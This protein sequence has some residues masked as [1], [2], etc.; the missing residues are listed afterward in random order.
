MD[1]Y[2]VKY[3]SYGLGALFAQLASTPENRI[4]ITDPIC[5][6]IKL[7]ILAC[8][9]NNT[10]ISLKSNKIIIQEAGMLQGVQRWWNDDDRDKLHQLKYPLLYFSGLRLG[11][12][13]IDGCDIKSD[14]YK[15]LCVMAIKGLNKLKMTYELA[16]KKHGSMVRNCLDDYI[17]SLSKDYTKEEFEKEFEI[18]NK[19]TLFIIYNEFMKKW[20]NEYIIMVRKLFEI[21]FQNESDNI[22]NEIANAINSLIDAKD[23]EIDS[24]R[25]D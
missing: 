23:L 4:E 6:V 17:K 5:S 19:P 20:N 7:G 12:L 11:H 25:P 8:K 15:H 9:P 2:V 24:I 13:K 16:K 10:R 14:C 18:L 1:S 21:A 22:K 3:A